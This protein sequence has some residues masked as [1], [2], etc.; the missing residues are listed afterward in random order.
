M[1]V[2]YSVAFSGLA[3]GSDTAVRS[4]RSST[5]SLSSDSD[6]E[7]MSSTLNMTSVSSLIGNHPIDDILY[8]HCKRCQSSYGSVHAFRKHFRNVHGTMPSSDD[9]LIQGIKATKEFV[10]NKNDINTPSSSPIPHR[11]HCTYCGWQCDQSNQT[12]FKKH[13]NEHY[14]TNGRI[15]RCF[16]CKEMTPDANALKF[17]LTKHTGIFSNACPLCF[18]AF[19]TETYL[20]LHFTRCHRMATKPSK[21]AAVPPNLSVATSSFHMAPTVSIPYRRAANGLPYQSTS[22]TTTTTTTTDDKHSKWPATVTPQPN[23][24][25]L[26][27]PYSSPGWSGSGSISLGSPCK[28]KLS[29]EAKRKYSGETIVSSLGSSQSLNL[30][31]T[32]PTASTASSS[33]TT[34]TASLASALNAAVNMAI[35]A[36]TNPATSSSGSPRTQINLMSLLDKVVEQGLRNAGRL[37]YSMWTYMH[38]L[39]CCHSSLAMLT[40][41]EKNNVNF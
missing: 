3:S 21:V 14:D 39:E 1:I 8:L 28:S 13:L 26:P 41:A 16:Y 36:P 37:A 10:A 29:A 18:I 19:E 12:A 22:V 33:V 25:K 40:R 4:G 31:P 34:P 17:H 24:R 20:S 15:Y 7:L 2:F 27:I 11:F 6:A 35:Q 38:L 30:K 9:V 32:T 23:L 5:P